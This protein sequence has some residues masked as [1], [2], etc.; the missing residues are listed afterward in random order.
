MAG[1]NQE[2]GRTEQGKHLREGAVRKDEEQEEKEEASII[3][4]TFSTAWAMPLLFT[5]KDCYLEP[6][7]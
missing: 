6:K 3:S 5:F 2:K 7:N 1:A 4:S